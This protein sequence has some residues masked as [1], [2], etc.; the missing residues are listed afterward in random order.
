MSTQ[1]CGKFSYLFFQRPLPVRKYPLP[2]ATPGV[3]RPPAIPSHIMLASPALSELEKRGSAL[4]ASRMNVH[5]GRKKF[6]AL[7][8][9][10]VATALLI[11]FINPQRTCAARVTYSTQFVC[12][13]VFVCVPLLTAAL[14]TYGYKVRYELQANAALK[15]FD[16]RISLERVI[17]FPR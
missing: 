13:C 8:T 12:V 10:P 2:L 3:E 14:L 5:S 11:T 1:S 7:E 15:V 6:G 4:N 9:G 16:S 17:C